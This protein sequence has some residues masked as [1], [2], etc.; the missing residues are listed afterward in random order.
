[1]EWEKVKNPFGDMLG[2]TVMDAGAGYGL[3]VMPVTEDMKNPIGSVHGGVLFSLADSAGGAAARSLGVKATTANCSFSYLRP[4]LS[5]RELRAE[6]EV[7]KKGKNLIVVEVKVFDEK[8]TLLDIG[9]FTYMK[10]E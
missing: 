2:M 8:G 3:C 5:V 1:M 7:V 9:T 10:I 4:A 6:A